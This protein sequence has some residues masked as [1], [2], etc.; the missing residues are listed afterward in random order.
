MFDI[1]HATSL[2]TRLIKSGIFRFSWSVP[3]L[4]VQSS[5]PPLRNWCTYVFRCTCQDRAT[6]FSNTCSLRRLEDVE[7]LTRGT[8]AE[9][10]LKKQEAAPFD[11]GLNESYVRCFDAYLMDGFGPKTL[12]LFVP[13]RSSSLVLRNP[14]LANPRLQPECP[15]LRDGL[16]TP[17]SLIRASS[18]KPRTG[19]M[20]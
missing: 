17:G 8:S 11:L 14:C 3:V 13:A 9:S 19:M 16:G 15:N 12:W 5:S 10:V 4:P 18:F 1:Y 2:S 6:S 20:N 7:Q